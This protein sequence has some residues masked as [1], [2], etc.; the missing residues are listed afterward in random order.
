[1]DSCKTCN[2]QG[3]NIYHFTADVCHEDSCLPLL[4]QYHN[5]ISQ[6]GWYRQCLKEIEGK[7][8]ILIYCR[9]QTNQEILLAIHPLLNC[10][11]VCTKMRQKSTT[12]FPLQNS[13]IHGVNVMKLLNKNR[14]YPRLTL[15]PFSIDSVK[16]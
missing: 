8:T 4:R 9:K 6:N 5:E 7:L 10:V 1:M 15:S 11:V 14:Y 16:Y 13:V 2:D 3:K 12:T